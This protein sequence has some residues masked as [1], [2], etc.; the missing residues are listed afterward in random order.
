MDFEI[1]KIVFAIIS[2]VEGSPLA[3]DADLQYL[4]Y[5]LD[6]ILHGKFYLAH[7]RKSATL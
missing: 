3:N 7:T 1:N 2:Q 4:K 6:C 5:R